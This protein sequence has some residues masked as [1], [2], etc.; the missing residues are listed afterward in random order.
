MN[1]METYR[2]KFHK[3]PT[4]DPKTGDP[5]HINSKRFNFSIEKSTSPCFFGP[6]IVTINT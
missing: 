1:I 6:I 4:I 3:Y 5:I 2:D